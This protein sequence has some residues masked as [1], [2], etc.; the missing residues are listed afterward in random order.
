MYT[1]VISGI[2]TSSDSCYGSFYS[3]NPHQKYH[4]IKKMTISQL[5]SHL[6]L[7]WAK[8][9][10]WSAGSGCEMNCSCPVCGHISPWSHLHLSSSGCVSKSQTTLQPTFSFFPQQNVVPALLS[11]VLWGKVRD[12]NAV[13]WS[14]MSQ[15]CRQCICT[16]LWV[17]LEE[18]ANKDRRLHP[19]Y[20]MHHA[21]PIIWLDI[22]W[23]NNTLS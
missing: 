1:F 22:K 7:L 17:P 3:L 11:S 18:A 15:S 19:T 12:P 9:W 16:A 6:S 21:A 23:V 4:S 5:V 13:W 10:Y 2:N 14:K 8:R 20:S